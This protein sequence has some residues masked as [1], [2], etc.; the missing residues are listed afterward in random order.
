MV[1]MAVSQN[2]RMWG[3][4]QQNVEGDKLPFAPFL[5]KGGAKM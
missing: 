4:R 1:T 2:N 5:V 3:K